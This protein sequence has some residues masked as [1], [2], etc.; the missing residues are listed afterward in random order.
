MCKA[1]WPVELLMCLLEASRSH[2]SGAK[3]AWSLRPG[4][5]STMCQ[6]WWLNVAYNTETCCDPDQ[7]VQSVHEQ[8]ERSLERLKPP[9]K[10]PGL[11][12]H[13]HRCHV[14]LL[15]AQVQGDLAYTLADFH[16]FAQSIFV[17]MSYLE[18]T[19]TLLHVSSITS[20]VCFFLQRR[21]P[22]FEMPLEG[23]AVS[24]AQAQGLFHV[25]VLAE[26]ELGLSPGSAHAGA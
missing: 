17:W 23:D 19:E 16:S 4:R 20:V 11:P 14:R 22:K 9:L 8:A 25:F 3:W 15:R 21:L 5:A 6:L 26:A 24:L 2:A 7:R 12:M 18:M 1:A 10:Y 13:D